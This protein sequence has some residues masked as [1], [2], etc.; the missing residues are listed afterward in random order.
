MTIPKPY[1]DEWW[2]L[3]EAD[4]AE[5]AESFGGH[6]PVLSVISARKMVIDAI[7]FYREWM[8]TRG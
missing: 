3:V 1:T 8:E 5:P 6:V 2:K 4:L 7:R